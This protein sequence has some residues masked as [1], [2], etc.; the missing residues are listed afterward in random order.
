[1]KQKV[2]ERMRRAENEKLKSLEKCY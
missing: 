1:V 2:A